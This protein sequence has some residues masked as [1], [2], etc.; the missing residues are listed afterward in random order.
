MTTGTSTSP[1]RG[2][3][4][5]V[6]LIAAALMIVSVFLPWYGGDFTGGKSI[7]GW[8]SVNPDI[9]DVSDYQ[10]FV[11]I[12]SGAGNFF[13]SPYFAL[14]GFSPFFTGLSVLIA[15]GV[16][17]LI[18]LAMLLSLRGGAFRL[19]VVGYLAL[20]VLALL[21][22]VVGVTNLASLFTTGPGTGYL[23]PEYGLYLLT[24]G[25]LLGF[26]AV[27]VGAGKGSS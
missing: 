4:G 13:E 25:A 7:T 14:S 26:L 9:G 17:A 8:D 10:D 11:D 16:L 21:V 23:D 6:V 19:P 5:F 1:R 18:G 12:V 2:L 15:G 24:G 27:G 22:A 20:S 3:G